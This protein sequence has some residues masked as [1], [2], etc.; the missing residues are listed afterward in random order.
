MHAR[1]RVAV[2]GLVILVAACGGSASS[3]A[4]SS[5]PSPAPAA[6]TYWLRMI[7]TQAI[8]P[9]NLFAM[10]PSLVINGD[11]VVVTPG[12]V[13]AIYPGPLLPNLVGRSV[14]A[15]GEARIVQAA[16][17]L[18]LLGGQAD[19]SGSNPVMGAVSGR[20]ELTVDSGRV[21]I[22][23]DPSA[24][25]ECVTTPCDP[26]PGTP[27]AFGS[28]WRMLLDLPS[29]L[30][31]ELGPEST[32]DAPAFALLVG[33]APQPDPGLPQQP[34]DWPLDQPLAT[35]GGPVANGTA[36]CGTVSGSDADTLR[37]VLRAA[38]QLSPWVQDPDTS[39]TFG[40]VVR[41]L[42]T[43]ENACAE[44]FGGG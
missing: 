5:H 6:A 34:V 1:S 35:F 26:A 13:P 17:D 3:A 11:G 22:T 19:F 44:V 29:W 36:R 41:P 38:N 33:P 39:A 20:I 37:P 25:I 32:Y 31:S 28:F 10:Q 7:T 14:S 30:A 43:G 9:V 8:P 23:G 4:P 42:V 24:Q 15:A 27:T 40:L 18:G 12:P 16:R 21:T 2:V